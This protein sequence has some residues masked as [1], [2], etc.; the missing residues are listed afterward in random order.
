MAQSASKQSLGDKF[1][2]SLGHYR[3]IV[4]EHARGYFDDMELE[5]LIDDIIVR[6]VE[7]AFERG[8]FDSWTDLIE[9]ACRD[10]EVREV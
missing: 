1:E 6:M 8:E 9:E 7:I 2:A 10:C 5:A 4:I 3:S